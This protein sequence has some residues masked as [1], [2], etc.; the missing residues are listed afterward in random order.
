ML[1]R[2]AT[3]E[4]RTRYVEQAPEE[5][6]RAHLA[7]EVRPELADHAV[8]LDQLAPEQLRGL[9]VVGR[10]LVILGEGDRRVDF[11]GPCGDAR[12]DSQLSQRG[13]D[14]GVELGDR[15]GGQRD[16][17]RSAVARADR[18][19]MVDEVEFQVEQ[20][21]SVRDRACGQPARAHVQRDLP[22]V[23]EQR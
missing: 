12:F 14:F 13:K 1:G 8:R 19:H 10:V 11:V 20:P 18:Q 23:V 6:H 22:P 9:R 16:S 2:G 3:R 17:G 21:V 15:F 5:V 4:P 7:D